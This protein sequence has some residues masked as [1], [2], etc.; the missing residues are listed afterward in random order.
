M[1]FLEFFVNVKPVSTY[2]AKYA[3]DAFYRVL[4]SP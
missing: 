2:G 4:I 3:E 1:R